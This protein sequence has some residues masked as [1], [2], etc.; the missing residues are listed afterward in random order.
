MKVKTEIH[1]LFEKISECYITFGSKNV[2]KNVRFQLKEIPFSGLGFLD[3]FC[4]GCFSS[5]KMT[6]TIEQ[7]ILMGFCY[8]NM[9]EFVGVEYLGFKIK[10][11]NQWRTPTEAG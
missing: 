6:R 2:H 1:F 10:D 9:L 4:S 7:Q 5:Q 11:Q 8:G 3:A